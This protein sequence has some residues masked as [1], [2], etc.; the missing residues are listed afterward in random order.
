ML[1]L[2]LILIIVAGGGGW[3]YSRYGAMSLS[4]LGLIALILLILWLTGNLHIPSNL[5]F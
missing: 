5:R 1:L 4:P 2:I 3:G